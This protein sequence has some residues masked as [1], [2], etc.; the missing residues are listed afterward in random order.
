M[1]GNINARDVVVGGTLTGNVSAT[2][3]VELQPTAVVTLARSVLLTEPFVTGAFS[4]KLPDAALL[5]SGRYIVRA[6]V[7]FGVDHYIGTQREMNIERS[8]L[9][10]RRSE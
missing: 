10:V 4:A 1:M 9:V 8:V 6:I 7:D 5:P 2:E 3:R